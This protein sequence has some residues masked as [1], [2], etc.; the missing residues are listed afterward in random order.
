MNIRFNIEKSQRKALAQKIGELAEM[1]VRYCRTVN[2]NFLQ[3]LNKKKPTTM[4]QLADIWYGAQG[5]DYGRTHHYN[6][7]RYH[8]LNFHAT[9]TKG[10]IDYSLLRFI[11]VKMRFTQY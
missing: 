6:D 4:A 11:Q 5:C 9:F 7:S 10:T 8:M 1:D 2:P 3:Q